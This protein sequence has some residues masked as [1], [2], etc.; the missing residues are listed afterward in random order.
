MQN[1]LLPNFL[2]IGASTRQNDLDVA[3]VIS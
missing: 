3:F 1:G 2:S